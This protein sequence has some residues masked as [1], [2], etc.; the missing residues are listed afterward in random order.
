MTSLSPDE[1]G[2]ARKKIEAYHRE[3]LQTFLSKLEVCHLAHLQEVNALYWNLRMG[4]GT[5][6]GSFEERMEFHYAYPVIGT[7]GARMDYWI[8]LEQPFWGSFSA[9]RSYKYLC[10]HLGLPVVLGEVREYCRK[11]MEKAQES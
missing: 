9:A 1:E 4:A 7:H 2:I 6:S 10:D 11:L 8:Y 3:S 5:Q